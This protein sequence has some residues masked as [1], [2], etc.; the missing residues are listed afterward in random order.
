MS[1]QRRA[2]RIESARQKIQCHA[3]AIRAQQFRIAQTCKRMVIGDKIKRFTLGLQR[4]GRPHH[5]K[6]IPDVQGTAGL[7]TG[8]N[9][10]LSL[11]VI[12]SG[13]EESQFYSEHFASAAQTYRDSSTSLEMTNA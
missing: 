8:K 11:S 6:V 3:V 13:V 10:H 5:A 12:L 1:K 7:D 9:S 2:F 4:H